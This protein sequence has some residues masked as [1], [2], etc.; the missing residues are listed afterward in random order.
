MKR[1][2][3]VAAAAVSFFAASTAYAQ[4]LQAT[5]P[6]DFQVGNAVLSAGTYDFLRW[7]PNAVTVRSCTTGNAVFH[8]ASL[9]DASPAPGGRLVFNK[10]GERYFLSEV[11]GL[12]SS[13]DMR[14]P[15]CALEK[16]IRAEQ[17][18][19]RTY[20]RVTVPKPADH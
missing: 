3:A 14:L 8:Q 15:A 6:F 16:Q 18:Q 19:V 9:A 1:L 7:S 4:K 5:I 12:P 13:G 17:G 20:E 2:L 10:Y 11:Q